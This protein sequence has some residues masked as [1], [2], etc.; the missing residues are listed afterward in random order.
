MLARHHLDPRLVVRILIA[1]WI[2]LLVLLLFPVRTHAQ[3]FGPPSNSVELIDNTLVSP[4]PQLVAIFVIEILLLWCIMISYLIA[5]ARH[6]HAS[7]PKRHLLRHL[8]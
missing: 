5:S 8:R 4:A 1:L 7:H 3:A 6:R 2:L